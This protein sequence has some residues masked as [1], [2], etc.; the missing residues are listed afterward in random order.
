MNTTEKIL[1]YLRET[2]SPEA[3]IVYGSFADGSEG[4][5]S[6]FDALVIAESEK[7]HD[8][9][10][11]GGVV[12]DVFIRGAETFRGKFDPGEYVQVRD[13]WI[14]FDRDGTAARLKESVAAFIDSRPKKSADEISEDIGWCEKMVLRAARNDA[15]GYFRMH[16]L[17]VE[18]LEI[19]CDIKGKY[20]EGPKKALRRM[21]KTD[22]EAF[23]VYAK[24]LREFGR[25]TLA[26]WVAYLRRIEEQKAT[27]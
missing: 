7:R 16:L 9:S 19:Y 26:A 8:S 25:E 14:V 12:L 15:E 20:Y 23:E 11:I 13:G 21:E 24:A 3:I 27:R 4:E 5:H 1:K 10:V 22:G 2:Y 18:S 17:L 6:D